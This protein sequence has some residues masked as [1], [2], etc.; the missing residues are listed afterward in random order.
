MC[1][2]EEGWENRPIAVGNTLRRLVAKAAVR[3]IRLEAA[4]LLQPHQLG[5]GVLQG[6]E[7]AAHAARDY[8]RDLPED[9]AVVKLDFRNAFN[10]VKRDAVLP[11]VRD[12]FPSLFPFISAGYSKPSVLLFGEH[13]NLSSEG[14]PLAPL[15]LGLS[16]R[17]LTSC[18]RSKLNIWYLDDGT[19]AG[20]EESLVGDLQLVKTQGEDLGLILNPSK[21]EIVTANQEIINAVRRILPEVSTTPSNSTLLGAPLGH[22][23]IDTVLKDKLNDLMRMEER[24]SDLDAHDALYLLTRCLTMPRLT[25]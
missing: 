1:V 4:S 22:Q 6:S 10:I 3:N 25:S 23:A 21:C 8:I 11:A 15:L 2:E 13:E 20:T 24:I 17:E 5:F 9:K 7:A 12:W 16:V 18:L 14:D 19:L